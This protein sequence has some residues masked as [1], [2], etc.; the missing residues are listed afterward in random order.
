MDLGHK[1]Y[2]LHGAKP[3]FPNEKEKQKAYKNI[4][5]TELGA[6]VLL[7]ILNEAGYFRAFMPQAA[8]PDNASAANFDAGKKFVCYTIL[9]TISVVIKQ[10]ELEEV[11]TQSYNNYD[12][13]ELD[14]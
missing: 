13:K 12:T 14:L 3:P 4:F 7:D 10:E 9:N 1:K 5:G 2:L 11:L 6:K 8:N